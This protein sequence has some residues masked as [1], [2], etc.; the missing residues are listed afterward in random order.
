[1]PRS[2]HRNVALLFWVARDLNLR[3]PVASEHSCGRAREAKRQID[4]SKGSCRAAMAIIL[5]LDMTNHLAL[6][7]TSDV[8]NIA[9][10]SWRSKNRGAMLRWRSS[11][12]RRRARPCS[13]RTI[14]G[15]T[16]DGR[17]RGG[18][19]VVAER[20][21][22]DHTGPRIEDERCAIGRRPVGGKERIKRTQCHALDRDFQIDHR[23]L[24]LLI[25]SDHASGIGEGAH[26]TAASFVGNCQCHAG[27]R[28]AALPDGRRC[29]AA[30][31]Q[32]K[33]THRRSGPHAPASRA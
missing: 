13:P 32:A 10:V 31:R 5:P 20:R 33:P 12:A 17:G 8:T 2:P 25:K 22:G 30:R 24:G 23:C 4:G 26:G 14:L 29:G 21:F 9:G 11:L 1:M 6:I 3:G 16:G 19:G 27:V 28:K 18:L 15:A 7:Q